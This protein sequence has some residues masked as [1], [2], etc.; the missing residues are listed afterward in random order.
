M[1]YIAK[2][3][4]LATLKAKIDSLDKS[5][6]EEY[7][8]EFRAVLGEISTLN[9]KF[10]NNLKSKR[11]R[12]DEIKGSVKELFVKNKDELLKIRRNNMDITRDKLKELLISYNLEIRELN[13]AF[14][15]DK[16][17]TDFPFDVSSMQDCLVA[18]KLETE[19]FNEILGIT[20][21]K[22]VI[23]SENSSNLP[24]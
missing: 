5:A 14:G 7:L 6:K 21:E 16:K 4:N 8:D 17:P 1:C 23:Y 22:P 13:T 3:E 10:N 19:C 2:R 15:I 9:T 24:S 18:G 11:D 20:A 12:L